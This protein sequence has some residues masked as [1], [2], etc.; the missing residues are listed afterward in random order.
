MKVP[1]QNPGG[2]ELQINNL[3]VISAIWIQ[4]LPGLHSNSEGLIT[5]LATALCI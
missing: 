4:A 5:P 2:P 3:K 1:A